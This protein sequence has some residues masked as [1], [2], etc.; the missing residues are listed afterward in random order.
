MPDT[1]WQ[2]LL[3]V[4]AVAYALTWWRQRVIV[5]AAMR[6]LENDANYRPDLAALK[7]DLARSAESETSG[8]GPEQ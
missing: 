6:C 2:W 7:A 5:R 8:K 4:L 1:W 3:I